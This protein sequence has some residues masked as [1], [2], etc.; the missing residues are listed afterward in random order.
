MAVGEYVEGLV[1]STTDPSIHASGVSVAMVS[2]RV[3]HAET[4]IKKKIL[5]ARH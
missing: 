2:D 1:L 4:S 3:V 5:G